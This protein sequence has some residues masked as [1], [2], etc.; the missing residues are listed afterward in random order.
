MPAAILFSRYASADADA[1][2][3]V[4]IFFF[5]LRDTAFRH[6]A[7]FAAAMLR[8]LCCRLRRFFERFATCSYASM[9]AA[10]YC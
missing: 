2:D 10:I 8:L 9:P 6:A 4:V 3:D 5:S 1:A 7:A